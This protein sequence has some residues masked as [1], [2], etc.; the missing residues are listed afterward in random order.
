[1]GLGNLV[2]A[3]RKCN[4]DMARRTPRQFW[5]Q[6][7][8]VGYEEGIARIEKIFGHV[9]RPKPSEL[10]TAKGDSLWNCYFSGR[11]RR[12]GPTFDHLKIEQF[13]K[14]VKDVQEMTQRQDAAT[15]YATRQV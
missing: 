8:N 7:G 14:D 2:L 4:R 12:F 11:P 9:K 13:K 3:H 15:K 5:E 1:N 10:K 6:P